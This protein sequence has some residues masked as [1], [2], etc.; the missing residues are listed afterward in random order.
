MILIGQYDSP[1]VRRTGIALRLYDLPPDRVV[2]AGEGID[3]T[4]RGDGAAFR[5]RRG[6][7][8]PLLMYAG[9][10]DLSKNIPLLLGY[11]RMRQKNLDDALTNFRHCEGVFDFTREALNDRLRYAVWSCDTAPPER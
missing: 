10:A 2:A 11:L 8:G 9:R 6:L 1:F 4:R 5:A 7:H 3:L